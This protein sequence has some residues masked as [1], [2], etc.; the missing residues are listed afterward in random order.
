MLA[1]SSDA[2]TIEPRQRLQP[3]STGVE[4]IDQ[5]IQEVHP[6]AA[7]K[8]AE[9]T[10][11]VDTP[12]EVESHNR[13]KVFLESTL[14]DK[15]AHWLVAATGLGALIVSIWA[16]YLLKATLGATRDA[17]RSADDAVKVTRRLGIMQVRAYVA[18][19]SSTVSNLA[20]GS[21][22]VFETVFR[23]FGQSPAYI[24]I[25]LLAVRLVDELEDAKFFIA[26]DKVRPRSFGTIS[27]SGVKY[28]SIKLGK[29]LDKELYDAVIAGQKYFVFGG[30]IIYKDVFAVTRR[31]VF[32]VY[33]KGSD[34]NN[35]TA[36]MHVTEKN[37]RSN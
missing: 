14:A 18:S 35:G 32:R 20:P 37:N 5:P 8:L 28:D 22:P 3:G 30:C 4:S 24:S 33:L 2:E 36:R 23:N 26:K 19:Y 10:S 12:N 6:N 29:P 27:A 9:T 7:P 25:A 11:E 15:L 16:V 21:I 31:H 13:F 1:T 34:I 17:V